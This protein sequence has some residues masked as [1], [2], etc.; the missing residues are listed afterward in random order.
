M[1]YVYVCP[2]QQHVWPLGPQYTLASSTRKQAFV[3][4]NGQISELKKSAK[5]LKYTDEF[6]LSTN[7]LFE[8]CHLY[9]IARYK[10]SNFSKIRQVVPNL[11]LFLKIYN[12]RKISVPVVFAYTF[13]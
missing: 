5:P 12:I 3:Q 8:R 9:I 6:L 1:H 2:N 13:K 4:R 10:A 11:F 7:E